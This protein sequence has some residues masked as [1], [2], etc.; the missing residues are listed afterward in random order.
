MVSLGGT[1]DF[2]RASIRF[3]ET[4]P[5]SPLRLQGIHRQAILEVPLSLGLKV[6]AA[7]HSHLGPLVQLAAG[8]R[9]NPG[10]SLIRTLVL[11][12]THFHRDLAL[13]DKIV[14]GEAVVEPLRG[15]VVTLPTA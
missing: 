3:L 14:V 7:A 13:E 8:S 4:L 1:K 9:L 15:E 10:S 6:R 11:T 12:P 5:P 2:F